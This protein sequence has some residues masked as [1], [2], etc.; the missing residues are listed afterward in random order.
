MD[1]QVLD[2]ETGLV[3]VYRTYHAPPPQ[4]N[5]AGD[6]DIDITNCEWEVDTRWTRL[7]GFV[8]A[9]SCLFCLRKRT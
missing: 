3:H 8:R 2:P 1:K 7:K 6:Q 4:E 9:V 5:T